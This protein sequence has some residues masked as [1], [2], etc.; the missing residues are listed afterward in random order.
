M[1]RA[2]G[3]SRTGSVRLVE[4]GVDVVILLV[5]DLVDLGGTAKFVA[6]HLTEER[7]ARKI[8]L[9][10]PYLKS[11]EVINTMEVIY[12]G[13]VPKDTWIITP[14][15]KVE[16]LVK[17]VPFWRENGATLWF[18][19]SATWS[20]LASGWFR[21]SQCSSTITISCRACSCSRRWP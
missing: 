20:R 9:I 21:A 15:E 10:A 19:P 16:T 8:V 14:R 4:G 6:K 11:T 1:A 5:E 3:E 18:L 2:F 13:L 7:G 17:R 12:F